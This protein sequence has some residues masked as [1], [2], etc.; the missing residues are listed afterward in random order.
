[1]NDTASATA[2]RL[3]ISVIFAK[4]GSMV[5]FWEPKR[6]VKQAAIAHDL[7]AQ[8][9]AVQAELASD[10]RAMRIRS[11]NYGST[12]H[13]DRTLRKENLFFILSGLDKSLAGLP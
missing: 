7:T 8:L 12:T 5:Q 9:E 2:R 4:D 3:A 1:M 13:R 10:S 11:Y 6:S